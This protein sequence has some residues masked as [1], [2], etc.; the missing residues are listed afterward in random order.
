MAKKKKANSFEKKVRK[1]HLLNGITDKLN[2]KKDVQNTLLET[3]KD[4]LIGVIGGGLA[5]AAIGKP[6][7]LL[8]IG[9]TGLGHYYDYQI[10]KLFG[11]GLMAANGF[12]DKSL[13]GLTGINGVKERVH[14]YKENF[15]E[16]FYITSI[17]T[18]HKKKDLEGIGLGIGLGSG[19][20]SSAVGAIQFFHYPHDVETNS[21]EGFI[22]NGERELNYIDNQIA[23]SGYAHMERKNIN[24]E[25]VESAE[26]DDDIEHSPQYRHHH[27]N[28]RNHHARQPHQNM[29]RETDNRQEYANHNENKHIDD[30]NDA[31]IM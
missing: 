18:K 27:K 26:Q 11:I 15:K 6:S 24:I 16:K 10:A 13:K 14:A 28:H 7:L 29:H 3:G 17:L 8:G 9:V 21:V 31:I 20:G 30:I 1:R 2:T 4:L 25:D 19:I 23:V 12:Q 5:G 22:N